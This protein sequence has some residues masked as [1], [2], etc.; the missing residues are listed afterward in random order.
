MSSS[1][2]NTTI[3]GEGE[4]LL[5]RVS[6][7][8]PDLQGKCARLGLAVTK[9]TKLSLSSKPQNPVQP[10]KRRTGGCREVRATGVA[11]GGVR[12]A[13]RAAPARLSSL[14]RRPLPRDTPRRLTGAG[15]DVQQD[16]CRSRGC[17]SRTS[18]L[19][20]PKHLAA[21]GVDRVNRARFLARVP[22]SEHH[23]QACCE[24]HGRDDVGKC[25]AQ[26]AKCVALP[27]RYIE[28]CQ[29]TGSHPS[30][31]VRKATSP[32]NG[33]QLPSSP[34]WIGYLRLRS[35][36][37]VVPR[38]PHRE[39]LSSGARRTSIIESWLRDPL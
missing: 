14:Q 23:S 33:Q 30:A 17:Q 26:P 37:S 10:R 29:A 8:V 32:R 5:R 36:Q 28:A 31:H 6:N 3:D 19:P 27:R 22:R 13:G 7:A 34:V 39:R 38:Y 20:W 9:L 15:I 1:I 21:T 35:W 18:R 16:Q 12:R 25:E 2:V 24:E 11:G 4:G